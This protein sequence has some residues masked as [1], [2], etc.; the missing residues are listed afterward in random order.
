MFDTLFN[1]TYTNAK[2][3][4]NDITFKSYDAYSPLTNLHIAHFNDGTQAYFTLDNDKKF[5]LYSQNYDISQ[6]SFCEDI[7]HILNDNF[8]IDNT[9][10]NF[11]AQRVYMIS[12]KAGKYQFRLSFYSESF[13]SEYIKKLSISD[14]EINHSEFKLYIQ[15]FSDKGNHHAYLCAF[16][17]LSLAKK[18]ESF[19]QNLCAPHLL[20]VN[21]P[22]VAK[23]K[24]PESSL[25]MN[26]SVQYSGRKTS[27]DPLLTFKDNKIQLVYPKKPH[28]GQL[29]L[30]SSHNMYVFLDESF[31]FWHYK[32]HNLCQEIMMPTSNSSIPKSKTHAENDISTLNINSIKETI[33]NNQSYV[34]NNIEKYGQ[35]FVIFD[36]FSQSNF[37]IRE[38][39]GRKFLY[40]IPAQYSP[41]P[42]SYTRE[43]LIPTAFSF[44]LLGEIIETKDSFTIEIFVNRL[45]VYDDSLNEWS[46]MPH[47]KQK[48]DTIISSASQIIAHE[49]SRD[50]A[51]L[52]EV[53]HWFKSYFVTFNKNILQFLVQ[54]IQY[55]ENIK[56]F[57]FSQS[58][59]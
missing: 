14:L 13:I 7:S 16:D 44:N 55:L 35:L 39:N 3:L 36:S 4:G 54:D 12:D 18:E 17:D 31:I 47:I 30:L 19:T 50:N 43:L 10:T 59:R 27:Y 45:S 48:L 5:F 33:L 32:M 46:P 52:T 41:L 22:Y 9:I 53:I 25:I 8:F 26:V 51:D 29:F 56:V 40:K 2:L 6:V 21:K 1:P 57:S 58:Y 37:F 34:L 24:I 28:S 42:I 11:F 49:Q 38:H 23:L 15:K 20:V